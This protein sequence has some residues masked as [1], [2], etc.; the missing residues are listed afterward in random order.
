[1]APSLASSADAATQ[2]IKRC[3]YHPHSVTHTTGEYRDK[4]DRAC[5][6]RDGLRAAVAMA[7]TGP[8]GGVAT[9]S[10]KPTWHSS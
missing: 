10:A 9:D 1:M 3:K 6:R 4:P 8:T 7:A 5:G 2:Q